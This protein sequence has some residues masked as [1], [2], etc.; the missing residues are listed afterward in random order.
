MLRA[1][2]SLFDILAAGS[3]LYGLGEALRIARALLAP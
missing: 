1:L 3:C 2:H